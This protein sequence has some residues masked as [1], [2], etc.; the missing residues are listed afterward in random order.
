MADQGNGR[1][2]DML[3]QGRLGRLAGSAAALTVAVVVAGASGAAADTDI[4][5]GGEATN[6]GYQVRVSY[7][8]NAAP[9]GGGASYSV[10][11]TC[12]WAP[13]TLTT[14]VDGEDVDAG[15]NDDPKALEAWYKEAMTA[16]TGSFTF[17]ES[18]YGGFD[19]WK[20]A[21]KRMK[22]GEDISLYSINCRDG[23]DQCAGSDFAETIAIP[24]GTQY[25]FEDCGLPVTFGFFP[26]GDPPP[27]AVDPEDLAQAARDAMVIPDPTVDRNPKS[28][29]VAGATLVGLPTWFWVTNPAAVG[30]AGGERNIRA[31][32]E[33]GAWA[34]VTATTGGLTLTS[35]AGGASCPPAKAL[36]TYSGGANSAN[37]CTMDF[38]RASVGYA[39]GF[40]VVA[41]TQWEATWVGSGGTGDVLPGLNRTNTENVPVAESQ[42]L[43]NQTR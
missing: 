9:S 40:P 33:S 24:A 17:A 31:D 8:G 27:P 43:V 28:T 7:S 30:G 25:S 16:L 39:G 42:A 3:T 4:S 32:V 22:A 38:S 36:T 13:K 11:A 37:A 12:W 5:T 18:Q 20:A 35:P 10:P 26:T 34:E 6:N 21:F 15:E 1:S 41:T 19:M 29:A 23:A 2:Q 14:Y